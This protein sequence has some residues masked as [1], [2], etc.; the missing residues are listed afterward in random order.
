MVEF[1]RNNFANLLSLLGVIFTAYVGWRLGV[2]KDASERK[3]TDINAEVE[4]RDDLMKLYE[5]QQTT[6]EKQ[7]KKIEELKI[8]HNKLREEHTKSL[9]D[10]LMK[11]RYAKDLETKLFFMEKEVE[12]LKLEII[13]LETNNK[14]TN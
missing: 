7:D 1:L 5:S 14:G 8:E 2:I 11:D 13:K 10:L 9:L 6:I 4:L 12:R 3:T